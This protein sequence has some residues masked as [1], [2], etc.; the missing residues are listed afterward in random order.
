MTGKFWSPKLLFTRIWRVGERPFQVPMIWT[1]FE[2]FSFHTFWKCYDFFEEIWLDLYEC[3]LRQK[4]IHTLKAR[5]R[6][7][8]GFLLLLVNFI[9]FTFIKYDFVKMITDNRDRYHSF[10]VISWHVS[11]LWFLSLYRQF[12]HFCWFITWENNAL[13]YSI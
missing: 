13:Y 2:L 4:V 11:W 7:D 10:T 6:N 8:F 1:I 3:S 9:R 5:R 12:L